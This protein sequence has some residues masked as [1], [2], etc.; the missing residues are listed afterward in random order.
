VYPDAPQ[1]RSRRRDVEREAIVTEVY[2]E[3]GD[4]VGPGKQLVLL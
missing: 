1:P 3:P 2:V 4:A